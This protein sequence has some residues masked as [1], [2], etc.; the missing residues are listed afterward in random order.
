MLRSLLLAPAALLTAASLAAQPAPTAAHL[1]ETCYVFS[2]FLGNGESG[3]HLAWSP[4]GYRWESL[5]HG[6]SYLTPEVGE[7]KLMRDPCIIRGPDGKFHMVWT[8]SW[9]G[10]TIGYASSPDLIHWSR[11]QAIPVMAD[12]PTARNCWAPE[13]VWDAGRQ[14]YLIFWATTIP[15]KFPETQSTADSGYNHRMYATTTTDFQTFSPTRLFYEPGFNVIDAT[16]LQDGE[17]W[18][19]IVKDETATPP[20]KNLRLAFGDNP[21]GPFRD[22]SAPFTRDWVEGPSAI[23]IGED[24]LVYFDAYRDGHYEALRSRDLK[25]WEDVTQQMTFPR[26]MKHGT[27]LAVPGAVVANLLEAANSREARVT[28]EA[29]AAGIPVSPT[30]FG[31]FFED[32]NYAADGGLY[33]ELVQNRSFEHR[34]GLYAWSK[35]RDN[36]RPVNL[37]L[38]TERP[39]HPNNPRYLRLVLEPG[40]GLAGVA[41]AGWDGIPLRE[42]ENYLC[43]VWARAGEGF[44]GAL[45]AQLIAADGAM[46]AQTELGRPGT[47]WSQLR[48]TLR[49][50]Q[51]LTNASLAIVTTGAGAVD[52]DMISLFP[53][54]TWKQRPNGLRADLVQKLADLQPA[55]LRFPGGCIVEGKDLANAYRWKDTVGEV[56]ERKQNWNRWQNAVD[57]KAPQYYQTYGLGFFEYFLLAADLGAEPVPILNCGMS[58]Q[59]QDGQLV[60]LAE[61]QPWIQDALDLIEFANGPTNTTWGGLRARMGHP[62]PFNLKLLG[63]GNEQWDEVYFERYLPFYEAIKAK[64]PEIT[65]VTTSGPGVDDRWWRL[66]WDKFKRGTPAEIVDEHYY[67]PPQW[68]LSQANRY[69]RYDRFGPK[70]FAGEYAAHEP[71]RRSTL[72]AALAEAAFM[73]GLLRNADLVTLTA[74]APLFARAGHTQWEPDLIWFDA[75]RV[76]G[77]PSYYVQQLYSRNR[78]DAALPVRVTQPGV[79]EGDFRGMVGVG[80]WR[81]RAEFK[82][83]KVTRDGQTLF[84]SDFSQGLEGWKTLRGRWET[85]GGV[86]RQNSEEENVQALIGDPNWGEYTY[87]LKARKLGGA[88][89][90][91]IIF[92]SPGD[93]TPVWWNLGGWNNTEHGLELPD[94][95]QTR[96]RGR[97]ETGRWYDIRIECKGGEVKCY[98]DG[99]L[100]QE[101]RR[102]PSQAVY[103]VAG[104]DDRALELVL[105]AVNVAAAPVSTTFDLAGLTGIGSQAN[106]TTLT[107][108]DVL[109]V[110]SF[111]QPTK[112]AP[113]TE[114]V[115]L[116]GPRFEH[117]LPANSLSVLRVKLQ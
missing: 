81:T 44:R 56:H 12:E 22:L 37:T 109:D 25:N 92:Q 46:L 3:L 45:V 27:V 21:E 94:A 102:G 24:Y 108:G 69:D 85:A 111:T 53:E 10:Q 54:N 6:R 50:G 89:G 93:G 72:R 2:Y 105:F 88:E 20:K 87:E 43:S 48:A 34:D 18:V 73:T 40:S 58:C 63:I 36:T 11:Q 74:Y 70:V 55:F 75:T 80:T 47:E 100:V 32:I 19:L 9:T 15:G 103:A 17:R 98:L 76:Y 39:L 67:R 8:T 4:D 30:M 33:A 26:G 114:T 42:G 66:A 107:S 113:R 112:V 71:N 57:R 52:L 117:L 82:D 115:T 13:I 38:A 31:V 16:L 90:F 99:R 96:T 79:V 59:Y 41:N 64:H 7:S 106:V 77:T 5:N 14:R 97:I 28:V 91:L 51:T 60:P 116:S 62:A 65:I 83:L 23:K 49:A 61:L 1:P 84:G 104:R 101:A 68:F 95:G 110:N 35:P 78:P 86:L 29:G